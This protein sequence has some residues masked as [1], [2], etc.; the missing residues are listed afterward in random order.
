MEEP[1]DDDMGTSTMSNPHGREE[2]NTNGRLYGLSVQPNHAAFDLSECT[3]AG[4]EASMA[5][6][7]VLNEDDVQ[8]V[9]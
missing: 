7:G 6:P 8:P 9:V 1:N 5:E 3:T 4:V 2:K